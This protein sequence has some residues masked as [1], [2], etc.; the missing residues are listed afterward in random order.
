MSRTFLGGIFMSFGKRLRALRM[1]HNFTQQKTADMLSVTMSSY[2]KY[3]QNERFPSYEILIKIADIF[4]V[5]L[6]YLLCRDD[7]IKSHEASADE[8]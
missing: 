8:Y 3:E 7:F 5:S 2:Q 4:D 1:K 6:D